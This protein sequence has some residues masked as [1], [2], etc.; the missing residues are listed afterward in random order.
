MESRE[1]HTSESK[2]TVVCIGS[3]AKDIFFPTASGE[4][5][6]TP[7]DLTSQKKVAFEVGAKYQIEDRFE[8]LGGVAANSSV[9]LSRLGISVSCAGAVGND[10]I[11]EWI[12]RELSREGVDGTRLTILDDAKSD[13]S[14]ILVFAQTG[15]RTIFYNRDA[16]ECFEVNDSVFDGASWVLVS[17]LN[18]NWKTHLQKILAARENFGFKLAVNPG[19]RN[20][21]D[22]PALVLS[23]A[24]AADVLL[25]NKDEAIELLLPVVPDRSLLE[26]ELFLVKR[27]FENGARCIALTDGARGAW[28]YDGGEVVH[29]LPPQILRAIDTTGAGDAFGSAFLAASLEGKTLAQ[30]I[31]WGLLN[32]AS[33]VCHFGA[34]QGL[35]TRAVLDSREREGEA[36][37]AKISTKIL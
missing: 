1:T 18:G 9:G 20:L 7:E 8:S 31:R 27:L 23:L 12:R 28:G 37:L 36:N 14:S 10:D 16:A 29:A 2:E 17:A 21:Q 30:R 5:F 6:E 19:Q 33:V 22:D 34:I 4:F 3:V 24:A 11:G 32:G 13:L 26:D 25:L 35:L 15:E